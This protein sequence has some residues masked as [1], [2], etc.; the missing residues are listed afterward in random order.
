LASYIIRRFSQV[1]YGE[2]PSVEEAKE[3][4]AMIKQARN[5]Y[6]EQ[7]TLLEVVPGTD[8]VV[9]SSQI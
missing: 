9:S 1:D 3:F 8:E 2:F 5:D 6:F 7:Y 4:A